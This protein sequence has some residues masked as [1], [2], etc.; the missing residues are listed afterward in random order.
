MTLPQLCDEM[1]QVMTEFDLQ[2]MANQAGEVLSEQVMTPSDAYQHLI[3]GR[4]E[5]VRIADLPGR[6]AA[7]MVVPYPARHSRADAGRARRSKGGRS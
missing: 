5:E 2:A 4:T 6:V 3:H 1:H 7:L